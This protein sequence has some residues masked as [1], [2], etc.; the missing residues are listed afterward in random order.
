M[1]TKE[2][3]KEKGDVIF[4]KAG[5]SLLAIDSLLN[6]FPCIYGIGGKE[7]YPVANLRDNSLINIWNNAYKLDVFRGKLTIKDLPICQSCQLQTKCNLK[8]CRLRSIYEGGDFTAPVSFC[9]KMT[10]ENT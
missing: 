1:S 7:E 2:K 4:C 10:A 6:V 9:A 8:H 5:H 3:A